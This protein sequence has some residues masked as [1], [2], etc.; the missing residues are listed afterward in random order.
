MIAKAYAKINIALK[1]LGKK[2][3]GYHE[4][5]MVMVPVELHDS[6]EIV[7]APPSCE[8]VVTS[9]DHDLMTS[10][11]N[12]CAVAVNKMRDFYKFEENFRIHIHKRIPMS[13]GLGGG[14][15]DAAAV[16]RGIITLL[17]LKVTES[18]IIGVS[19][20]I[21]SDVPFF[22]RQIPAR[23]Q[24]T[25]EILTPIKVQIPYYVLIVKPHE[26]LSTTDVFAKY[27]QMDNQSLKEI[28]P[29][30]EALAHGDDEAV[31]ETIFN[32]LEATST[33]MCHAIAAIKRALKQDGLPI[34][35]MSGSGT[36]V[37]ALSMNRERLE[38]SAKKLEKRGHR[39]LL[40]QLHV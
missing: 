32:Q 22:Y 11:Y 7:I 4:L 31:A 13:A 12:L 23:V 20:A 33:S 1:V 21:G 27:D 39:V 14:S 15:S 6:I 2:P 36:S 8:T 25:G 40:T 30:I 34:V 26:G 3:D 35:L 29:V 16:I 19:R 5:D 24:G 28:P 37:F 17:K 18:D 9:D 10:E 38:I